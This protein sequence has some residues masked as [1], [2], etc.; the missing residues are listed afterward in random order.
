MVASR[1]R[2]RG[3]ATAMC[4]DSQRQAL[5]MGY[6][7]LQFNLVVASNQKAVG[8]W[9]SLGFTIV[10]TL[11]KAFDH[12]EDGLVDAH[13]MYKILDDGVMGIG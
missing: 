9:Q 12:I 13:I 5:L 2:G 11:P 4:K 3:V 1:M 7:A 8:L 6:M 10:G